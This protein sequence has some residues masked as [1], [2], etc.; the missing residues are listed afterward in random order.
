MSDLK[1]TKGLKTKTIIIAVNEFFQDG[2]G[3]ASRFMCL[4]ARGLSDLGYR[5]HIIA[6]KG[7][8]AG[9]RIIN[10]SVTATCLRRAIPG[11]KTLRERIAHRISYFHWTLK[12]LLAIICSR[13]DIIFFYAPAVAFVLLV[14]VARL[15]GMQTFYFDGDVR[16]RIVMTASSWI[17]RATDYI[18]F[19]AM[20]YLASSASWTVLGGTKELEAVYRRLAP[21]ARIFRL[22]PP[23]DTQL[24][25]SGEGEAFR[26]RRNLGD[27]PLIGYAGAV[28]TNEGIHILLEAFAMTRIRIPDAILLLAG[29]MSQS[30]HITGKPLDLEKL[31]ED[32]NISDSVLFLGPI[33]LREV[34]DLYAA[35]D[36]L[37][38][39]KVDH[40]ANRV[41][42]PIKVGEYL[43]SGTP[44][45]S[46][47]VGELDEIL[48]DGEEAIFF[49]PGNVEELANCLTD[50]LLATPQRRDY[51]GKRAQEAARKN[52]DYS[53]W[54]LRIHQTIAMNTDH[55]V[56]Q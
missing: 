33:P 1:N 44:M 37:V 15:L 35:C 39:P 20:G 17:N 45:I 22:Y 32:L 46:S 29:L 40:L 14:P 25:K 31:A 56:T 12:I 50:I 18:Q 30:L 49:K 21:R 5:V 23:T 11:C 16:G 10:D 19:K 34:V 53:S 6:S 28:N 26:K 36:V 43:A 13:S 51:I 41:A 54:A 9:K 3:A 7:H 55:K 42:S 38:N 4:Q 47:R 52:F 24:F 8:W 48:V 27:R 2:P